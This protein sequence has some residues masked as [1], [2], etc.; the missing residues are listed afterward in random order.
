MNTLYSQ[1]SINTV[2]EVSNHYPVLKRGMDVLLSM[3][4]VLVIGPLLPLLVVAIKMD[5]PGPVI[6]RQWRY[7][8]QGTQFRIWKFRTLYRDQSH[9]TGGCQV[10]PQDQRVTRLGAFLR[11]YSIDELPQLVNVLRGQMSLV[12]PRPHAVDHHDH[13]TGLIPHYETRLDVIPGMTGLAQIKGC[14]GATPELQHMQERFLLD[15]LYIQHRSLKTDLKIIYL[16][17]RYC[18]WRIDRR[19]PLGRVG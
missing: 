4:A 7:G 3:I 9:T 13:Y 17:L 1:P 6:F 16:T 11:A 18:G 5:S 12:G 19:Q 2:T 14:R 10:S 15:R 8:Y